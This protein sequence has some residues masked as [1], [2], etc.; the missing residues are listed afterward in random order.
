MCQTETNIFVPCSSCG[1][2]LPAGLKWF[3]PEHEL[4]LLKK[5]GFEV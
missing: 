5:D 4:V 2:S 3:P 1:V